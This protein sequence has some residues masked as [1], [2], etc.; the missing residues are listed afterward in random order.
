ML[1]NGPDYSL[2][3]P[4]PHTHTSPSFLCC[5]TPDP[6]PEVSLASK[7]PCPSKASPSPGPC[8]TRRLP[9]HPQQDGDLQRVLSGETGDLSTT[10]LYYRPTV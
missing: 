8:G 6:V 10:S 9:T 3:P 5:P 1:T 7:R 2:R 4:P